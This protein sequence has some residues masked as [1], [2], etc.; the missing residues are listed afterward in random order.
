MPARSCAGVATMLTLPCDMTACPPKTDDMSITV[1]RDPPR[2][3]SSAADN[4]EIPAPTT[5]TSVGSLDGADGLESV[6]TFDVAGGE[7]PLSGSHAI[8][9][10]MTR[11]A[12]MSCQ[13]V[14][15]SCRKPLKVVI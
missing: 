14:G 4:P 9:D 13:P 6:R 10:A 3:R 5:I 11:M 1:T 8:N 2:P 12:F 15:F 7:Q